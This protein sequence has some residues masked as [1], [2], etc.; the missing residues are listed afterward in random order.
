[1]SVSST[2]HL[3]QTNPN[4]SPTVTQDGHEWIQRA[5]HLWGTYTTYKSYLGFWSN[6]SVIAYAARHNLRR[7]K[8]GKYTLLRKDQV[9]SSTG[10][11]DV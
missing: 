4:G 2:K 5:G 6:E 9:D 3:N 1:M 7:I 11:G 8:H 10:A